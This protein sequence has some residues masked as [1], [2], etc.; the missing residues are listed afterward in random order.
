[1][2]LFGLALMVIGG[3]VAWQ[4]IKADTTLSGTN[5]P[6]PLDMQYQMIVVKVGATLF[7]AGSVFLAGAV[8]RDS[9]EKRLK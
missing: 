6:S 3:F 9:L 1:M 5:I 4:G 2:G 7:L 8:V